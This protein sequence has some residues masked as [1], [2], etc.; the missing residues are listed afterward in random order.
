VDGS[1]NA[2][3]LWEDE[4][5]GGHDIYFSYRPA[6][7]DWGPNHMVNDDAGTDLQWMSAI[8]VDRGGNAYAI[9]GDTRSGDYHDLYDIYF[10][11]RPAGGDWRPNVMV[12]DDTSVRVQ[13][14][15]AIAV[16]GG[17]NAYAVWGDYRAAVGDIYFSYRPA[18]GDWGPDVKVSDDMSFT[19]QTCPAI[20]VDT[21]GNAYAVWDDFRNRNYDVYFSY[22]PAGGDWVPN[23][24]VNDNAGTSAQWKAA[25]A[26]DGSGSAYA[27]WQDKR[28]GD[29]DIYFSYRPAEG[30]TATR[31][32]T[33]TSTVIP[34]Q[35]ATLALQLT[36][37]IVE[38]TAPPA[39]TAT[40]LQIPSPSATP[41]H[42][43]G[44]LTARNVPVIG[45]LVLCGA[46]AALIIVVVGLL[47]L[48][49]R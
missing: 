13:E 49:K 43:G 21:R 23:V 3:A 42:E 4:R 19:P 15:P 30:V 18:G 37:V 45:A 7:G 27:A 26:V 20:A 24:R 1:G 22:R 38:A 46:V 34:T 14:A 31:T 2:Y 6:G 9:W 35:V 32:P 16:D 28:S 39:A 8:A 11:Y 36:P 10:S 25:I 44:W 29:S 41:Y 17:G 5:N 12:N 33:P 47:V 40:P 48:R